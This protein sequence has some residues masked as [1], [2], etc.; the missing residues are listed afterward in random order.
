MALERGRE[1]KP[2]GEDN[3]PEL[4]TN[5][6]HIH[7]A[8]L[9]IHISLTLIMH[10]GNIFPTV[11]YQIIIIFVK[12]VWVEGESLLHF[13]VHTHVT[14]DMNTHV[15]RWVHTSRQSQR[16]E[17]CSLLVC[18]AISSSMMVRAFRTSC[19]G[20]WASPIRERSR[21]RT[22]EEDHMT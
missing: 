15:H 4:R 5:H 7:Y 10:I 8:Q 3:V 22:W 1:W 9:P 20:R 17:A 18:S 21:G 12:T 19:T 11:Y 2:K 16:K 14:M 13:V 6:I